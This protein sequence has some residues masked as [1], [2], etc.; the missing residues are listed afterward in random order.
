MH[1]PGRVLGPGQRVRTQGDSV[2]TDDRPYCKGIQ[3]VVGGDG[4]LACRRQ[5]IPGMISLSLHPVCP[6]CSPGHPAS[7]PIQ[8]PSLS[9]AEE[10]RG[11]TV[12]ELTKSEGSTLGLTVS[13]GTDKDGKP[14]VSSLKPGGLAAR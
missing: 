12:V 14:R 10:C 5:S 2:S 6:L 9:P 11:V 7:L 13:G 8:H 1:G 3:D 4:A